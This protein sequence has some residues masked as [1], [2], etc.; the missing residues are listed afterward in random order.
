MNHYIP[1]NLVRLSATF[2]DN[3]TST[4]VDPTNVYLRVR[5]PGG[6]VTTYTYGVDAALVKDSTGNY[7][8][9]LDAATRGEWTYRWYSTGTG[10]A[11]GEASFTIRASIFLET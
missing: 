8:L 9:D 3:S 10:Q 2:T 11:A 7:H 5:A 4:P 1:G 6:T